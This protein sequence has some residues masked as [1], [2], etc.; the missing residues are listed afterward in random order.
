MAL[1]PKL[2]ALQHRRVLQGLPS[3]DKV[4]NASMRCELSQGSGHPLRAV[5]V[6]PEVQ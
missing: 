5:V 2:S 4:Q 1:S 3:W 6:V